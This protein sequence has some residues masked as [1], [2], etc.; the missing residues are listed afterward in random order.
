MVL[1]LTF[2]FFLDAMLHRKQAEIIFELPKTA[3]DNHDPGRS[4]L[5]N[6]YAALGGHLSNNPV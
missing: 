2:S 5:A 1:A 6:V 4:I 3:L